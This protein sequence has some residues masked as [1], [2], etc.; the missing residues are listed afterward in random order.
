MI[1][2]PSL[3]MTSGLTIG[4]LVGMNDIGK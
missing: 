1:R 3:S 2:G 4:F